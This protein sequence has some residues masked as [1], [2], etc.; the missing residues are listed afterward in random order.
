MPEEKKKPGLV[1]AIGVGKKPPPKDEA[2][3]MDEAESP[4]TDEGGD[5]FEFAA[6]SLMDAI[7]S[8]DRDAFR[9]ALKTAVMACMESDY[10]SSE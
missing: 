4:E 1:L 3:A 5:D 9:A 2:T 6:D 10:E 7:E 8:K